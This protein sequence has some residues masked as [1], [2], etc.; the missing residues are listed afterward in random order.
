MVTFFKP[1]YEDAAQIL[2]ETGQHS[3]TAFRDTAACSLVEVHT[4]SEVRNSYRP[5]NCGSTHL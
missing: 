1:E 5:D 4:T 2:P 3:T